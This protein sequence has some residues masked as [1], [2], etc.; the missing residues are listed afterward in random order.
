MCLVE[1]QRLSQKPYRPLKRSAVLLLAEH[2]L[3]AA[4]KRI[5]SIDVGRLAFGKARL[6]CWAERHF[7]RVDDPARDI[8][9]DLENIG[10]IAVVTIAPE[11]S[12]AFRVD[13]LRGDAHAL[14]G[15]PDR[16]FEHGADTELPADG[17]NVDRAALVG[18]A[19]IA[20]DYD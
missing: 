14:A 9:L 10:Q 4:E 13:E 16:A 11:M 17:A 19:R 15:P 20:G 7:E 18:E 12:A 2:E 8:V 1:R 3:A 6:F 5:I